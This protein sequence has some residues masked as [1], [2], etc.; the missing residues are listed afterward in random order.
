VGQAV[1]EENLNI[2]SWYDRVK[3]RSSTAA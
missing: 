3:E 2:I 1:S